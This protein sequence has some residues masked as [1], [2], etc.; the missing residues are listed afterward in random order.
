M[1][2]QYFISYIKRCNKLLK[3][4][5]RKENATLISLWIDSIWSF[6]RYGCTI[7]Q[8]SDG[9]FYR[10]SSFERRQIVT[11]RKYFKLVRKTNDPAYVKYLEDKEKFN[12]KFSKYVYRKWLTSSTMTLENFT[13]LCHSKTGVIVKPLGGMEGAGIYK[14]DTSELSSP[15]SIKQHYQKL[16]GDNVIIE[17]II[18][19]HPSM[20]FN[21]KSVNTI[22]TISIMDKTTHEVNLF[23]AVLRAGVGDTVVDN[24]HQGGCCYEIDVNSGR[25]CSKGISAKGG[26]NII[27]HPSTDT[28]MLGYQIPYWSQVVIGCIEAHKLLPQ[29]RYISWDVAITEKGMELIEG[30]HNGDYDMI[31]FVGSNKYW[32]LLK[33]YL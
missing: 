22:R 26:D 4:I 6:F 23:K 32:P 7:R 10:Y 27:F 16:K 24:Y 25:V 20:I 30:N 15:E 2:I 5:R 31:E 28:C 19:Q 12:E 8:Y 3:D 9:K 17:E 33:K 21:N 13:M 1:S 29:C 11:T 14:I 18:R